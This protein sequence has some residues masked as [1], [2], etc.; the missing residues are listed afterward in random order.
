[1]VRPSR[2]KAAMRRVGQSFCFSNKALLG[3]HRPRTPEEQAKV[4]EHLRKKGVTRCKPGG[5]DD[6]AST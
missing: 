1:M 2:K 3:V 5:R 4:D 6:E